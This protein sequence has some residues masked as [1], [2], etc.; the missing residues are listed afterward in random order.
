MSIFGRSKADQQLIDG[1]NRL[2]K[3]HEFIIGQGCFRD[4][5]NGRMGAKGV[6][7]P[8]IRREA[9]KQAGR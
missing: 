4:P 8:A 5:K 2:L 7:P 3:Q 9:E 6:V 1:Q